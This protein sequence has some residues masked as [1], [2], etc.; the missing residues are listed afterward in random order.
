M[1]LI[2]N[3]SQEFRHFSDERFKKSKGICKN[4]LL[5]PGKIPVEE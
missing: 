2:E 1:T 4:R 3:C 5:K